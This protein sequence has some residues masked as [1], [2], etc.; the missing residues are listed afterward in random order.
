M[1][2]INNIIH[3]INNMNNIIN[4]INIGLEYQDPSQMQRSHRDLC[5]WDGFQA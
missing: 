2:N 1:N 4:I 5:I 3:I